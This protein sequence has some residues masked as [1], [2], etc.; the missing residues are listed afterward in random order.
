MGI[1]EKEDDGIPFEEKMKTLIEE[2][3]E[4]MKEGD[5]LDREIKKQLAKIG[6][7]L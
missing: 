4:Q 5:K 1:P 3:K 7:K 2:L 6:I